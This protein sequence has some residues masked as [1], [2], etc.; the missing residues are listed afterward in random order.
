MIINMQPM[1]RWFMNIFLR[2][3]KEASLQSG[4]KLETKRKEFA[5]GQ[6]ALALAWEEAGPTIDVKR[7]NKRNIGGLPTNDIVGRV[8]WLKRK[9][10]GLGHL[11]REIATLQIIADLR[12]RN[13]RDA[14]AGTR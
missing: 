1:I 7:I 2:I 3:E 6:K 5:F 13:A 9:D 14:A 12:L 4:N 11:Q 10:A 8:D